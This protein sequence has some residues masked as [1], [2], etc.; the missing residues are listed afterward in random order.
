MNSY[1]QALSTGGK[2]LWITFR[3]AVVTCGYSLP[4]DSS[5][6][7]PTLRGAR[8]IA[9]ALGWML[10]GV[11]CLVLSAPK[12]Y[13]IDGV[14]SYSSIENLSEKYINNAVEAACFDYIVTAES[15]WNPRANNPHSTAYGIGQLLNE[16]SSDPF[17]Q[18][19]HA[20]AYGH[21]RYGTLCNAMT[22]HKKHWWW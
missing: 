10:L 4:I 16:R 3:H 14:K 6:T 17:T 18:V 19:I 13:A 11:L 5:G 7:L 21:D 15:H 2:R 20:V 9:Q 1:P 8:R 22:F 12:A